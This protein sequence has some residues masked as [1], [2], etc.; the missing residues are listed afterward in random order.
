MIFWWHEF[1]LRPYRYLLSL[2]TSAVPS[3]LSPATY[4]FCLGIF[5]DE[6]R[7]CGQIILCSRI[8]QKSW[9]AMWAVVTAVFLWIHDSLFFLQHKRGVRRRRGFEPGIY[10]CLPLLQSSALP[11]E[12]SAGIP[13]FCLRHLFSK[14]TFCGQ[15]VSFH[16][17]G[18]RASL[19]RVLWSSF[20]E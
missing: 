13:Y 15:F 18:R 8:R 10:V 5:L 3:G 2:K 6:S 17:F 7:L 1:E 14:S 19:L 9:S 20:S 16:E 4:A 12:L 11:T